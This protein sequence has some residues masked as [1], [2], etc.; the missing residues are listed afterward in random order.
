MSERKGWG[1]PK[2]LAEALPRIAGEAMRRQGFAETEIVLRW[3]AIVGAELA[4]V[5]LPERLRF[6]ADGAVLTVRVEPAWAVELQHL[7]PLLLD[8]LN[9]YFGYAAVKDLV[10]LQAPLPARPTAPRQRPPPSAAVVA[11]AAAALPA[12]RDD[13][14]RQALARL[15][16]LLPVPPGD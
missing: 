13:D 6:R 11:A 7:T 9:S 3:P 1:G 16:A 2:R 10:L 15:A 4:G 14:L 8:R 5:S 12:M